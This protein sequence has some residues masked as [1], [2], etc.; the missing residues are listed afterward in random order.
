MTIDNIDIVMHTFQF[1]VPGYIITEIISAIMPTKRISEGEKIIQTIGYSVLNAALWLWLFK[2]IAS[3]LVPGSTCYWLVN[4]ILIVLSGCLTGITLGVIR[5]REIVR[6]LFGLLRISFAHPVP[7]A[8]DYYFS[9]QE[10]CWMEVTLQN[11]KVLRGLYSSR[12]FSSS[13]SEYRDIYLEELYTKSGESWK[14]SERTAGIWICPE[15]IRY[16][17]LYT[18]EA[19]KNV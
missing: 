19:E 3:K 4:T 17:K 14:K 18:K 15:E 10:E 2:A 16:I 11:G 5:R 9:K 7:T 12:S 13:D 6:K 1:V 8:W